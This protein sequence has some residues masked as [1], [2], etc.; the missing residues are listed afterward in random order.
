MELCICDKAQEER[1]KLSARGCEQATPHICNSYCTDPECY[2][3]KIPA[4]CIPYKPD[5]K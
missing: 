2:H 5:E 4:T 3:F 1:L